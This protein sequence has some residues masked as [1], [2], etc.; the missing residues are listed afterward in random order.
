MEYLRRNSG[1]TAEFLARKNVCSWGEK[2]RKRESLCHRIS[3]ISK[4]SRCASSCNTII[5]KIIMHTYLTNKFGHS[6]LYVFHHHFQKNIG[7]NLEFSV[8]LFIFASTR[9]KTDGKN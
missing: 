2:S 5:I 3:I 1:E 8:K 9:K 7:K 4:I 6:I